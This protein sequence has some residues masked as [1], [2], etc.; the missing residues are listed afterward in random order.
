MD[1]LSFSPFFLTTKSVPYFSLSWPKFHKNL[2]NSYREH[3]PITESQVLHF[4]SKMMIQGTITLL[5]S[6][7]EVISP[8]TLDCL[9]CISKWLARVFELVG[10]ENPGIPKKQEFQS[11]V[12]AMDSVDI[13]TQLTK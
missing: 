1:F 11:F 7:Q 13:L 10:L 9:K 12:A 2:L 3:E 6:R 5:D 8:K 4:G